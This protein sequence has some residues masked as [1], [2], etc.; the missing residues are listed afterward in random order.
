MK[1]KIILS[2]ILFSGAVFALD[3]CVPNTTTYL[4]ST[5]ANITNITI[6]YTAFCIQDTHPICSINL[7]ILANQTFHETTN[8][9]NVHITSTLPSNL[10]NFSVCDV[11]ITLLPNMSYSKTDYPCNVHFES[12]LPTNE[13]N[14]SDYLESFPQCEFDNLTIIPKFNEDVFFIE[15]NGT[16]NVNFTVAGFDY[17]NNTI[18]VDYERFVKMNELAQKC[19]DLLEKTQNENVTYLTTHFAELLAES[20]REN[21]ALSKIIDDAALCTLDDKKLLTGWKKLPA[22]QKRYVDEFSR[23][24]GYY[25]DDREFAD[26]IQKDFE[27]RGAALFHSGVILES[28]R[29]AGFATDECHIEYDSLLQRNASTC[30]YTPTIIYSCLNRTSVLM[31]I[32]N[33]EYWNGFTGMGIVFIIFFALIAVALYLQHRYPGILPWV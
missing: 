25:I 20:E 32:S 26:V 2:L 7:S 28:Y 5:F 1:T 30:V 4:N 31:S 11:N 17:P 9:C 23:F 24:Y 15:T 12:L 19:S 33:D 6:N 14:L 8:P 29:D 16:C 27:T 10:S 13:T 22:F 18:P 21:D 3:A